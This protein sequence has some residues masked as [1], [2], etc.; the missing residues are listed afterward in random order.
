M[1]I[2]FGSHNNNDEKLSQSYSNEI[3]ISSNNQKTFF[4]FDRMLRIK[5]K[6]SKTRFLKLWENCEKS[7]CI[8]KNQ[9]N[10]FIFK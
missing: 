10:H 6:K 7:I 4:L 3:K 9:P 1:S 5:E 8:Q 2:E